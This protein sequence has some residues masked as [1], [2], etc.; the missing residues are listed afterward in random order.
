[1]RTFLAP[2][3]MTLRELLCVASRRK[4]ERSWGQ[5]PH[6]QNDR[7]R[8]RNLLPIFNLRAPVVKSCFN[9]A[10]VI[11]LAALQAPKKIMFIHDLP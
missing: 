10:H 3:V 6:D 4:S 5:V 2:H 9:G 11:V 8:H 1:M 7:E